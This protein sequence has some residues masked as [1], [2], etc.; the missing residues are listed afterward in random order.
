MNRPQVFRPATNLVLAG[1]VWLLATLLPFNALYVSDLKGFTAS[2]AVA[3]TAAVAGW[4][5]F[6]RPRVVIHS[7]HIEIFNPLRTARVGLGSI[8]SLETKFS[9]VVATKDV[10]IPVWVAPAPSRY[11]ARGL[12]QADLKGLPVETGA[13]LRAG[14]SPAGHSGQ[15]AILIRLAIKQA[16]ID[17]RILASGFSAQTNWLGIALLAAGLAATALLQF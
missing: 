10:S 5:L 14:D 11:A 4:L 12:R 9:L 6:W 17:G 3:G 15:A 1:V 16:N 2:L 8:E 7:D 13:G